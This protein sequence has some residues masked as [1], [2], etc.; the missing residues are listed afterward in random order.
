MKS[1]PY[2]IMKHKQWYNCLNISSKGMASLVSRSTLELEVVCCPSM[3]SNP[4]Q[5]SPTG[6]DHVS[7][8]LTAYNG[9]CIPRMEHS[10]ALSLGSPVTLVLNLTRYTPTGILHT[11]PVLAILGLPSCE[12]LEVVQD[13][14]CHHSYPI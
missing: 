11:P 6:L 4:D 10:M 9:S 5:I 2:G 3:Y 1:M 13:E 8:K 14:L 7:T 12:R